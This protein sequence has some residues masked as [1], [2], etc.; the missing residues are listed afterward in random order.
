MEESSTVQLSETWDGIRSGKT[1][2]LDTRVMKEFMKKH[3]PGSICAPY[4]RYSWGYSLAQYLSEAKGSIALLAENK[5]IAE[6][7]IRELKE[8]GVNIASV[9]ADGLSSWVSEGLPTAEMWEITTDDLHS[10]L[11]EYVT[12][13][14]REPYEWNSGVIKGAERVPMGDLTIKISEL[15]KDRKYA[16]VCA[17]GNRSQTAALFLS[18]N[19][20][21][22][23]SV[24]GGMADWLSK[25]F[26]VEY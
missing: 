22:A 17:H 10:N 24:I 6:E 23:G 16:V 9:I 3:V 19:G 13:D 7:A 8:N 15:P 4:S 2:L 18:D 14:V 25:D 5:T 12:L 20:F 1:I 11:G 26:P 21:N